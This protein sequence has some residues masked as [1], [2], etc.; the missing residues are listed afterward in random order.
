MIE[1]KIVAL[2]YLS[3]YVKKKCLMKHKKYQTQLIRV[4][5][6]KIDELQNLIDALPKWNFDRNNKG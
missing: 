4:I 3:L 1:F 6:Q 2:E 5:D